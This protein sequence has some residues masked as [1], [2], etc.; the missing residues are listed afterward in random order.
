MADLEIK[1][2]KI[3][4]IIA[5]D[6][7][8]DTDINPE[9]NYDFG[10]EKENEAYLAR[11]KSGDLFMGQ[12]RVIAYALGI[13]GV[14][15]LG[16]CH[17]KSNNAYDSNPFNESVNETLLSYSMI[18]NALSDLEKNILNQASLLKDFV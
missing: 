8:E 6:V 10:N 11:F 15:Y 5:I 18:E 4:A 9:D 14:D 1:G 3:A 2:K 16:G 12:I 13:K 7:S 17:L